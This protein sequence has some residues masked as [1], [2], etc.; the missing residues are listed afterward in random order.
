MNN[1]R[2][3]TL[4]VLAL[5]I[6]IFLCVRVITPDIEKDLLS[7]STA[8]LQVNRIPTTGLTFDGRDALLTGVKGS[9]EVSDTARHLV[10]DVPG[11]RVVQVEFIP[12][13]LDP[14]SKL[15][16]SLEKAL[17]KVLQK[18]PVGFTGAAA[19]L[20]PVGRSALDDVFALLAASPGVH[21]EIRGSTLPGTEAV[22]KYLVAKGIAAGRLTTAV[23]P[24]APIELFVTGGK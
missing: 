19:V 12:G 20:T 24:G 5:G 22:K 4:G 8:A 1:R 14:V 2:V 23:A 6:I 16:L 3:V 9:P 18:K 7:R 11:V 17:Q 13:Q 21:V 15:N 10:E